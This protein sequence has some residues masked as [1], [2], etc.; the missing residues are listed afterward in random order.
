MRFIPRFLGLLL[1]LAASAAS[2][3]TLRKTAVTV[4][5]NGNGA[6]DVDETVQ[7]TLVFTNDGPTELTNAFITDDSSGCITLDIASLTIEPPDAGTDSS[8]GNA[9]D[10]VL[11]T[12]FAPGEVVTLTFNAIA[13]A[14]G[15]CCN[16]AAWTS[17]QGSGLSDRDP[18]DAT[19]EQATCHFVAVVGPEW[20]AV[21][22]K[23]LLSTGCLAPGSPVDFRVYIR[24]SGQHPLRN[25]SFVDVLPAGFDNVVVDSGANYDPATRRIYTD[26]KTWGVG[27]ENSY[28]YHATLPCTE[29]GSLTNTARFAFEDNRGSAYTRSDSET[30]TWGRPELVDS[31]ITWAD[32]PTDGDTIVTN[33][34]N[35]TFTVVVRN[36]GACAA[37]NIVVT[38]ALDARF[39]DAMPPLSIDSGGIYD[40]ANRRIEW[41]PTTTPDLG[42]IAAGASMTLTFTTQVDPATT[43]GQYIPNTVTIASLGNDTSCP[44]MPSLSRTVALQNGEVV[45]GVLVPATVLLRND[46]VT[47]RDSAFE[48]IR[49]EGILH[50]RPEPQVCS[51]PTAIDTAHAR[52][53]VITNPTSPYSFGF[54]AAAANERCPP[55]AGVGGRVLIFYE[56]A[57]DCTSTL[58]VTRSDS[59]P[60]GVLVSW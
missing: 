48:Q 7:Y 45:Y 35:V 31:S 30:V 46:G 14:G 20:D 12:P 37:T 9:I 6:F 15:S 13:T 51:D 36:T 34:E 50:R 29:R 49:T 4:D 1:C 56:L 16:Q 40:P 32:D 60:S 53:T 2:A 11:R 24:N 52:T 19:P 38:D 21:L 59:N 3:Q 22:D 8:S 41:N 43:E 18:S 26:P 5:A 28:T 55:V 54:D 25:G 44:G 27:E 47:C 39:M 57:D 23:Q 58:R 42:S 33:G 17:D 10:V